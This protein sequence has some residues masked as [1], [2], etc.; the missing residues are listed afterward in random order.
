MMFI[1]PSL[2][3][4]LY[5]FGDNIEIRFSEISIYIFLIINIL[6]MSIFL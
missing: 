3:L 1:L 6:P 5:Y 4:L 2:D